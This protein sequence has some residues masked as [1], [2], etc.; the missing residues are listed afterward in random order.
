MSEEI[1]NRIK[2]LLLHKLLRDFSSEDIEDHTSLI[3]LGVGVD[4][5]ATLEFVV[6]LEEEFQ[7]SIDEN[8]INPELLATVSSISDYISSR[9]GSTSK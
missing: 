9:I 2:K 7:I 5:V 6:A 4:S 3:G 8:E 1:K